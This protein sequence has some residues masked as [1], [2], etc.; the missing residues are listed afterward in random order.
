MVDKLSF[1]NLEKVISEIKAK[2]EKKYKN[3]I[4]DIN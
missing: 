3:M 1:L 4:V 2:I